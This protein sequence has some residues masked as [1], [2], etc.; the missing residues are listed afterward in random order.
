VEDRGSA[1]RGAF[2][3]GLSAPA[4]GKGGDFCCEPLGLVGIGIEVVADPFRD[5][6]MPFVPGV[7]DGGDARPWQRMPRSVQTDPHG[8][9]TLSRSRAGKDPTH[10]PDAADLRC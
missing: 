2:A 6:G 5:L 8:H 4:S 3:D 7:R 9:E 10:D 1:A